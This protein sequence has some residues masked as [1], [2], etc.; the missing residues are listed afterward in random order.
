MQAWGLS[1]AR[2]GAVAVRA[3]CMPCAGVGLERGQHRFSTVLL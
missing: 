1:M 3:L 2:S